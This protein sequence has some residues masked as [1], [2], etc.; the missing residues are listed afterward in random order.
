MTDFMKSI[1][2]EVLNRGNTV[3]EKC[4]QS[5]ATPSQATSVEGIYR[6]NYQRKKQ[7]QR[8]AMSSA[9]PQDQPQ[10]QPQVKSS[11]KP[12]MNRS[13]QNEQLSSLQRVSA[14]RLQPAE[15]QANRITGNSNVESPQFIGKTRNHQ[16][17]WYF[18][19]ISHR[20]QAFRS[21]DIQKG[22]FLG[23]I[24][25]VLK[26]GI[27]FLID[28]L[29]DRNKAIQCD[30]C[31][32]CQESKVTALNIYSNDERQLQAM[33]KEV[34]NRL[35]RWALCSIEA[36]SVK[37]PSDFLRESL[38]LKKGTSAAVLDGIHPLNAIALLERYYHQNAHVHAEIQVK[39]EYILI[40][41]EFRQVDSL[42]QH[43]KHEADQLF[44]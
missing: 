34:Y 43:L 37:N 14:P 44:L 26:P 4:E 33:L 25:G 1:V 12:Y 32:E 9:E 19:A 23:V 6:P 39:D 15:Q 36:Y 22:H 28:E 42:I 7:Q 3:P 21:L 41:G 5:Q 20:L 11:S 31:L 40:Q 8:V 13:F 27:L 18:P 38:G 35:N 16:Y 2:Q 17:I 29:L 30:P 24:I 10:D